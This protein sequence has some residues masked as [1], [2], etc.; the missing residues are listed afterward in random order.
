[1]SESNPI[2]TGL[3]RHSASPFRSVQGTQGASFQKRDEFTPIV[4]SKSEMDLLDLKTE[5]NQ[6][7]LELKAQHEKA[8]IELQNRIADA[9]LQGANSVR[10]DDARR[11]EV[12]TVGVQEALKQLGA[13]LEKSESSALEIAKAALVPMFGEHAALG[14]LV[15][16]AVKEQLTQ[17]KDKSIISVRFSAAD[18]IDSVYVANILRKTGHG[19]TTASAEENLAPG[20]VKFELALGEVWFDYEGYAQKVVDVL[21]TEI[22]QTSKSGPL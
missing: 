4:P 13:A 14:Q 9:R 8:A 12:L 2:L 16:A 21:T 3:A 17:L 1:M 5:I 7:K 20:S 6:L 15:T 18:M 11:T 19:K 22:S 10:V